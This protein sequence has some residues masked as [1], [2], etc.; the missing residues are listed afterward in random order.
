MGNILLEENTTLTLSRVVPRHRD[1]ARLQPFPLL[2]ARDRRNPT[3][4]IYTGRTSGADEMS[5]RQILSKRKRGHH[6]KNIVPLTPVYET[7]SYKAVRGG[8]Q[9][10]IEEARKSGNAVDQINGISPR[11]ANKNGYEA[12]FANPDNNKTGLLDDNLSNKTH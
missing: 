10:Y 3:G 6:R 7:D 4:K 9:Y 8:E 1:G 11:K 2:L 5:V 12:A